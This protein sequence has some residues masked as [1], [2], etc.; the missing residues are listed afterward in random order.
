MMQSRF[1][2][3]VRAVIFRINEVCDLGGASRLAFYEYLKPILAA[4]PES[5]RIDP[6]GSAEFFIPNVVGAIMTTNHK[7]NGIYL[8]ADD[9]RH[10]VA[11]SPLPERPF[12]PEYYDGLYRW[13]EKEGG[14]EIVAEYLWKA[15]ISEFNP[16]APPRKTEAFWQIVN[17]GRPTE[18]AEMADRL[19]TLS[20]P[21]VV[22]L[23]Q[24]KAEAIPDFRTWL[25][26][27]RNSRAIL[28]RLE[29]CGYESVRNPDAT[30]GLWR[31]GGRRQAVYA[32]RE[33][34]MRERL[35]AARALR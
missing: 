23:D 6:K 31:I 20:H 5:L 11:W 26:D 30:D 34:S 22:T 33:L 28:Y 13:F 8:P 16:K 27:R 24:L 12:P 18:A 15:D 4:P 21:A 32:K 3:Y 1:N 14:N 17:S 29:D 2:T 10:Y 19:E 25:C 9:R 7:A 35:A